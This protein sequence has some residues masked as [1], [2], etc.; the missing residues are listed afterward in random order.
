MPQLNGVGGYLERFNGIDRM[1]P[2]NLCHK[3]DS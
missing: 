2:V 3:D 1:M